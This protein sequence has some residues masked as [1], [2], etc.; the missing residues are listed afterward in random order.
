MKRPYIK[1]R[2]EFDKVAKNYGFEKVDI[3]EVYERWYKRVGTTEIYIFDLSTE[4]RVW[5]K[6]RATF[7]GKKYLEKIIEKYVGDISHLIEWR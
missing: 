4:I 7:K 1:D 2:K 5:V 6:D 3:G